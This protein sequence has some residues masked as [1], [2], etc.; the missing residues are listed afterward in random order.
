MR[1]SINKDS[2]Q[3]KIREDLL[4]FNECDFDINDLN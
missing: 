2:M 1:V 4:N 3:N